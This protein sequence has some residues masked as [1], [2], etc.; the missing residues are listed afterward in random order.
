MLI[1][2]PNYRGLIW[3]SKVCPLLEKNQ[4]R[5]KSMYLVTSVLVYSIVSHYIM[6]ILFFFIEIFV[7]LKR[8]IQGIKILKIALCFALLLNITVS[9]HIPRIYHL[10]RTCYNSALQ[11]HLETFINSACFYFIKKSPPKFEPLRSNWFVL[12]IRYVIH[13]EQHF[14]WII[15]SCICA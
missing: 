13:R 9:K 4:L 6:R 3:S 2:K 14:H 1:Y 11:M 12:V 15:A 8:L 7:T 5:V 10:C